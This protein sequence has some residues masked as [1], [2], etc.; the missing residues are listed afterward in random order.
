MACESIVRCPAANLDHRIVRLNS[1]RSAVMR[2]LQTNQPRSRVVIVVERP[3]AVHEL[4]DMQHPMIT[5]D[6]LRRDA[7]ELRIRT[8]LIE[9][10]VAVL[11]AQKLVT[12]LAVN[13]NSQ[14]V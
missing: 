14:L 12:C 4:L 3:D 1:P 10:D 11:F 5:V 7:E 8:L 13:A 9:Q 6:R 2:V